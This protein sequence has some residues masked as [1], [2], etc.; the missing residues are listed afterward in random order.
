M[1]K[2]LQKKYSS[3]PNSEEDFNRMVLEMIEKGIFGPVESRS[4]LYDKYEKLIRKDSEKELITPEKLELM[5]TEEIKEPTILPTTSEDKLAETEKLL[6]V[7]NTSYIDSLPKLSES[8]L[9]VVK[10]SEKRTD[11]ASGDHV[12]V[13]RPKLTE[14]GLDRYKSP[15][16]GKYYVNQTGG[17][18][19]QS[20]KR[21]KQLSPPPKI[22][23][24][25]Q[26][27]RE[28]YA[29]IKDGDSK[30]GQTTSEIANGSK[31]FINPYPRGGSET[32]PKSPMSDFEKNHPELAKHEEIQKLEPEMVERI[33]RE[34]TETH[35]KVTWDEIAGLENV[36]KSIK[37]GL[38]E[39]ARRRFT[40]RLYVPLPDTMSRREIVRRLLSSKGNFHSLNQDDFDQV[41]EKTAGYS[42]ADVKT[43]CKEAAMGPL[44]TAMDNGSISDI[45]VEDLRPV[46]FSDFESALDAV[47]SSVSPDEI[48]HY[49]KFNQQY[50]HGSKA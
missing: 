17:G 43:L 14:P 24:V 2:L 8:T 18:A 45:K 21:S 36:K 50:G 44:R 11:V 19:C 1:L 12:A 46:D 10:V 3:E 40:K 15:F 13:K 32:Q 26:S 9:Q 39:A 4:S 25:V 5:L 42:G 6:S 20:K 33:L 22:S 38:D 34:V 29:R 49:I 16:D 41:A 7:S 27:A 35:V 31:K 48:E 28:I 37:D 30:P 47:M 23:S